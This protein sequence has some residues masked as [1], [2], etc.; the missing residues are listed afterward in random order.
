MESTREEGAAASGGRVWTTKVRVY[1]E[2]TDCGGIV[3]YANY[4]K[5]CE[6]ARTEWVRSSGASQQEMLEQGA[7]FVV[8]RIAGRYASS[9]RLDDLLEVTCVPVRLRGASLSVAQR[10]YNQRGELLFEFQCLLA[11]MDMKQGRPRPIPKGMAA[12]IREWIP[13]DPSKFGAIL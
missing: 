6:R 1:Y 8:A 12:F 5:F 10:I 9:A 13:S 4:L 2:D 11:F 7:G 3:Y